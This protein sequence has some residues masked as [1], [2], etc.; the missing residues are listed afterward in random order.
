MQR[1][2]PGLGGPAGGPVATKGGDGGWGGDDPPN[3]LGGPPGDPP[4]S[5]LILCVCY[6]IRSDGYCTEDVHVQLWLGDQNVYDN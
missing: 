3:Q 5:Q 4:N 6:L 2:P 1:I